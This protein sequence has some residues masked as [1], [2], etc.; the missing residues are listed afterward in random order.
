MFHWKETTLNYGVVL[1]VL[2]MMVLYPSRLGVWHI[3]APTTLD[4]LSNRNDVETNW[5]QVRK[6]TAR[7][8]QEKKR[9]SPAASDSLQSLSSSSRS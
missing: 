4:N 5:N 6:N 8:A 3:L 1:S 7:E 2:Y 9:P